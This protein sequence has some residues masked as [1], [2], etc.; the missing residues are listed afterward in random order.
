MTHKMT[1]VVLCHREGVDTSP[2]GPEKPS[3]DNTAPRIGAAKQIFKDWCWS[4]GLLSDDGAYA[5][6]YR[7]ENWDG[8]SYGDQMA[9]RLTLSERGA[10]IKENA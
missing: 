3:E 4:N 2:M 10:V 5:D 9:F 6:V 7:V 1:Y 8:V